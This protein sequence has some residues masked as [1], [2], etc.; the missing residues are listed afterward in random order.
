LTDQKGNY[1]RHLKR[2]HAQQADGDQTTSQHRD[3]DNSGA[4]SSKQLH[5]KES[6][7]K[8]EWLSQDPDITLQDGAKS[9]EICGDFDE[10]SFT[11]AQRP[12]DQD[13]QAVVVATRKRTQPLYVFTTG[14]GKA[15]RLQF[16]V[17]TGVAVTTV[18]IGMQTDPYCT[19]VYWN[20]DYCQGPGS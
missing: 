4:S 3:S 14:K 10:N 9:T 13:E 2:D 8:E 7:D 11:C 20:C 12:I 1:L 5:G 17:T 15:R 18:D 16:N 19:Q 6:S